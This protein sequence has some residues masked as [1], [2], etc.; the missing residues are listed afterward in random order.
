MPDPIP[1][2][3]PQGAPGGG[4]PPAG[5]AAP[6]PHPPGGNVGPVANPQ[7]NPG[8]QAA[9]MQKLKVA[10]AALQEALPAIPMG[11]EL[12][13]KVLKV[14]TDLS[15]ELQSTHDDPQSQIQ[16]LMQMIRA[17]PQQAQMQQLARM[18]QPGAPPAMPQPA[19]AP[20][21]AAA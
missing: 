11:S 1:F 12:H 3:M 8:N 20:A 10:L 15:K 2:Q 17:A 18:G 16:A 9:A 21:A 6:A 4:L 13:T 14:T 7:A 19:A 5:G